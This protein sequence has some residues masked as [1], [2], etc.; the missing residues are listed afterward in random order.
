MEG[1]LGEESLAE[2]G[3]AQFSI[4][5]LIETGHEQRDFIVSYLET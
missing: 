2:L 1:V 5:V 4:T 3:V